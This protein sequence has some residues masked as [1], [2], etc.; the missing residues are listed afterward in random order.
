MTGD[1]L[2]ALKPPTIHTEWGILA[3]RYRPVTNAL[4]RALGHENG[5]SGLLSGC[6]VSIYGPYQEKFNS[7]LIDGSMC[8]AAGS[9]ATFR[10]SG[11]PWRWS[12]SRAATG[13]ADRVWRRRG[14]EPRDG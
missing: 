1:D 2:S 7:V 5:V 9:I 14:G 12:I 6:S 11:P 10:C 4:C 8:T 13:R 3:P